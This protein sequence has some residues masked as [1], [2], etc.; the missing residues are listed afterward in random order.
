MQDFLYSPEEDPIGSGPGNDYPEMGQDLPLKD[1]SGL[2]N[3]RGF[4]KSNGFN[5]NDEEII[6]DFSGNL[7]Y[8]IPL[9]NY[10]L[11][12]DLHFDMK[13]VYNGSIG[14]AIKIGDASTLQTGIKNTFN[15]NMAEWILSVNGICVQVFN[16]IT[17]YFSKPTPPATNLEGYD[18]NLLIP[19]YHYAND[20]RRHSA[21]TE[22]DTITLLMG[23][24]STI[25]LENSDYYGTNEE[26]R[27]KG[28]Y[29]GKGK[30]NYIK[31]KVEY[32]QDPEPYPYYRARKITLLK[33]DGLEYVFKEV[34]NQFID[35]TE[36]ISLRQKPMMPMLMEINNRFGYSIK[37]DYTTTYNEGS[38]RPMISSIVASGIS[39]QQT[40]INF[41]FTFGTRI[42]LIEHL[43]NINE[44]YKIRFE[45]EGVNYHYSNNGNKIG[46]VKQI[47][48][49]LNQT[50]DVEYNTNAIDEYYQRKY[51]YAFDPFLHTQTLNINFN[52]LK[53]IREI[54]NFLDLRRSYFY[55]EEA[56]LI[57]QIDVQ[58]LYY[59]NP[60]HIVSPVPIFK[61]YGRDPFFTSMIEYRDEFYIEDGVKMKN[62]ISYNYVFTNAPRDLRITPI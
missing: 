60:Y 24:G 29:R 59:E 23:D 4:Y 7:I 32:L 27:Y 28:N 57:M 44:W 6:N 53:R 54:K 39:S 42:C 3:E 55:H 48:N 40:S 15:M 1:V 8:N 52:K 35:F 45:D 62:R 36:E 11:A 16:F 10:K 51:L 38:G 30:E 14:H 9:Y 47:T 13:L 46:R 37:F 2:F 49:C 31:A 50:F 41:G 17:K 56:T 43:T 5:F 20:F 12:G 26:M 19:G 18:I 34:K 58:F 25:T 33:G 22:R 21:E 61:G